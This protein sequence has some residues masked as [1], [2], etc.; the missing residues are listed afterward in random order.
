MFVLYR[1]ALQIVCHITCH[2]VISQDCPGCCWWGFR[3]SGLRYSSQWGL[4]N[5]QSGLS[6]V[7]QAVSEHIR[8]V[9]I[10]VRPFVVLHVSVWT[11]STRTSEARV[12]QPFQPNKTTSIYNQQQHTHILFWCLE[13]DAKAHLQY[14]LQGYFFVDSPK[15]SH[16]TQNDLLSIDLYGWL[17]TYFFMNLTGLTLQ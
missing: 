9:N 2:A 10:S 13:N 5:P 8:S 11:I 12:S 14:L 6:K 7:L 15:I 17:N 16:V 1:T 3:I 4:L